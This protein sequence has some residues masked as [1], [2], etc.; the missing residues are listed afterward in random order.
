LWR[1]PID[2][3]T[4]EQ[5]TSEVSYYPEVSPD[6]KW[7]VCK[8]FDSAP[9]EKGAIAVVPFT[10]GR[11]VQRFNDISTGSPLRWSSRD[12]I[13]FV[14]NTGD[15]SNIFTRSIVNGRE[16]QVTHFDGEQIFSFDWSRDSSQ[17]AL[18]R[19]IEA[20][21]VMM[22]ASSQETHRRTK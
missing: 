15:I 12:A 3:G 17:L 20:R 18:I 19:G 2:G 22:L 7:V 6:G 9:D 13:G 1:V 4:P 21:N 10:G 16:R 11:P 14:R 8:Y 5:L